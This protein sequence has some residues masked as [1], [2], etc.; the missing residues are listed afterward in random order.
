M[1]LRLSYFSYNNLAF[2]AYNY[3]IPKSFILKLPDPSPELAH[4]LNCDNYDNLIMLYILLSL[5]QQ[6]IKAINC[7]TY[8]CSSIP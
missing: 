1:Y 4:I 6:I 5:L 8:F 2:V 3:A 7:N